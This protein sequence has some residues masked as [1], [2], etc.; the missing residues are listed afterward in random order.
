MGIIVG[1]F[2]L[3]RGTQWSI[4]LTPNELVRAEII[5]P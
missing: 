4:F 2:E 1:V 5:S 3:Q